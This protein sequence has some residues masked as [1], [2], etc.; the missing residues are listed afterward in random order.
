DREAR[1]YQRSPTS[2]EA[3]VL[4]RTGSETFGLEPLPIRTPARFRAPI[5]EAVHREALERLAP[6]SLIVDESY[7][8]I[9]LSEQAGRYLQPSAGTLANDLTE[10]ARVELRFD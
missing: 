8:V 6:P 2:A 5:E 4:P 9:H 3:R 10:L 7:R 1:I